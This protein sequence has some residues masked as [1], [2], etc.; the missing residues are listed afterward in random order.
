VAHE[1]SGLN[2]FDISNPTKPS[3]INW[4]TFGEIAQS[5][6]VT[7]NGR[8]AFVG[9]YI[10]GLHMCDVSDPADI[11]VLD[12][13]YD[14]DYNFSLAIQGNYLY[15]ADGFWG[16]RIYLVQPQLTISLSTSNGI[17]LSWPQPIAGGAILQQSSSLGSA[18]WLAVTNAPTLVDG[19]NQLTLAP[20]A[21]RAF[22]RLS[23]SN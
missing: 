10:G 1:L 11:Q 14:T 19:R 15:V 13:R 17:V 2:I 4:A 23:I 9:S 18:S 21:S 12:T 3:G 5:V 16:L 6:A 7:E 8:Y 20:S 22:F